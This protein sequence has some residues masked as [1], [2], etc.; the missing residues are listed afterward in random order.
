M[1][2]ESQ[3]QTLPV[4]QAGMSTV[5]PRGRQRLEKDP[6]E[7][8]P[9]KRETGQGRGD[10]CMGKMKAKTEPVGPPGRSLW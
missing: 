9:E 3:G 4:G 2:A 1:Q 5:Y 6:S 10:A 8:D 7:R